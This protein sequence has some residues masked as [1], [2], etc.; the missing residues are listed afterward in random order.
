MD[1]DSQVSPI[2]ELQVWK[3]KESI[4]SMPPCWIGI[5]GVSVNSQEDR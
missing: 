1:N 4:E 3:G 5:K 2:R